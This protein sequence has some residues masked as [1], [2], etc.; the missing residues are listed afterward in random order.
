MPAIEYAYDVVVGVSIGAINAAF[1]A[2]FPIGEEV[3]AVKKL[4]QSWLDNPMYNLIE[5]WPYL[6]IVEAL[7]RPSVFNDTPLRTLIE[8]FI[9]GRQ[10]NRGLSMQAVDVNMGDI[11]VYDETTP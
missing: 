5:Q 7:W 10:F 2:V 1:L 8:D 4:K 6:S 11:I 3:A 9:G